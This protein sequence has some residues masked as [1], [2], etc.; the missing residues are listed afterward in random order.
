MRNKFVLGLILGLAFLARDSQ[1]QEFEFTT[2]A[3][4]TISSKSTLDRPELN[5]N[6]KAIIVAKPI[7]N[8]ATLNPHPIGAWYYNG[9]W[10]IFN[11]DHANMPLG[12]KFSVQVF[13]GA[14]TERFV[15]EATK[16]NL[17]DGATFIDNSALNGNPTAQVR[18][19][20]NHGPAGGG[21]GSNR[22]P[23]EATAE[24]DASSG[25]WAIKN[26]NGKP[27]SP[28]TAF[29][30]VVLSGVG[31]SPTVP[32][33]TPESSRS[34]VPQPAPPPPSIPTNVPPMRPASERSLQLA[35]EQLNDFAS[36]GLP[37]AE[38]IPT[39]DP[40]I[41]AISM[42]RLVSAR[43]E[44]SLTVLL[45]ALQ[46]AGFTVI[47][48]DRKI[49]LQPVGKGQSL[50][51]YDFEAVGSLKLANRGVTVSLDKLAASITKDT[52]QVPAAR[53]TSLVLEEV[54]AH[55]ESSNANL[56]F[57]ARFLIELGKSAPE[58][59]DLTS[60]APTNVKLTMLQ[61]SLLLRRLQGDFYALKAKLT[62]EYRRTI[63]GA[64]FF[65]PVN[66]PSRVTFHPDRTLDGP[67]N[68][69]GDQALMMDAVAIPTTWWNGL[70]MAEYAKVFPVLEKFSNGVAVA[71]ILLAWGKL[72]ASVS[73]I[74]GKID[75]ERP[76]P[77]VRTK[78]SVPGQRRILTARLWNEVGNLETLN[79]LRP[80]LNQA[81]GLDFNL[82]SSGP[83]GDV[84]VEWHFDGDN[85]VRV[86][87]TIMRDSNLEQ[88]FVAF[89]APTLHD[90]NPFKQ[91]TDAEGI[92]R[93]WVVGT[94]KVPAVVYQ[95][96]PMEVEKEALV[97][98][99]VTLKSSKDFIQN[100]I[101][102]GGI[103][104]GLATGGPL[105]LLGA[106]AEIGY[107]VPYPAA[108]AT[109]PVIDHEECNG[110]WI[111]TVTYT[112]IRG[113]DA[114]TT[115]RPPN[116]GTGY[117][118]GTTTLDQ[119]ITLSGTATVNKIGGL[120]S[121]TAAKA[122]E[123]TIQTSSDKSRVYCGKDVGHKTVSSGGTL[124]HTASG[125]TKTPINVTIN[126][127]KDYYLISFKP[128]TIKTTLNTSRTGY[129]D[130]CP[131]QK[132]PEPSNTTSQTE[133]G[134]DII[135]GRATYGEDPN[136]LSGST[137]T[138]RAGETVTITWNLRRCG[139]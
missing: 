107:R 83:L 29:N 98:I 35:F 62:G 59:H 116:S 15:H 17:A 5:G 70:A 101:D 12:M 24:Y 135:S 78:N 122:D 69:T 89:D 79:C 66:W 4:N 18:I 25:R 10:N 56:R 115:T 32:K 104:V 16:T 97:S 51:F 128:P 126:T 124:T 72:Y 131:G 64:N 106:A 68:L 102:I 113:G 84:A 100:W 54:R 134:A 9:K 41:A 40:D 22:S 130:G 93:M 67:C 90:R 20:Q 118:G 48:K 117:L 127:Q 95:R 44:K 114:T 138:K 21:P 85:Q 88:P 43:G 2:T 99:W 92:S 109:V 86:I 36:N 136:T 82:P 49:L 34:T 108:T 3:A 63:P 38:P 57:W 14:G 75:V 53:F 30:V 37:A 77:L 125:S 46:M 58:P 7:G 111:G 52:P 13:S 45:A 50:G 39:N 8:T 110:Q 76:L 139:N 42:A 73:A 27:L 26:T 123:I 91:V 105:G 6:P 47:D 133:Y 80:I 1:S 121:S 28:Q 137:T 19:F 132:A 74:K 94:P 103:A 87:E 81:T 33:A 55:A 96:R 112:V 61:A 71:N 65:V 23:N 31:S 60:A 11:T 120:N 119:S 129:L